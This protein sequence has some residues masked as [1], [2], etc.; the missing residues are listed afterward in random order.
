MQRKKKWG[1]AQAPDVT[2]STAFT[3]GP[4]MAPGLQSG[5]EPEQQVRQAS[6]V[7]ALCP[8]ACDSGW[9]GSP[10]ATCPTNSA[11]FAG[12][13]W[14]SICYCKC[15]DSTATSTKMADTACSDSH[16]SHM[17]ETMV[18]VVTGRPDS[19]PE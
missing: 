13:C 4:R 6:E 10:M 14:L 15:M 18:S 7:P 17:A 19:L 1:N 3:Q 5:Q 9:L 12:M 8:P 16:G 2:N 11:P